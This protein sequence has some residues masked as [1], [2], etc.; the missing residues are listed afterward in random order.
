MPR[1]SCG[2]GIKIHFRVVIEFT[3]LFLTQLI[4]FVTVAKCQVTSANTLWC[5][6]HSH[7]VSN[8]FQLIGDGQTRYASS[9]HQYGLFLTLDLF[10]IQFGWL[11]CFGH[12]AHSKGSL[13][14][15]CAAAGDAYQIEEVS[16]AQTI[17]F[18]HYQ[19]V[20]LGQWVVSPSVTKN[21]IQRGRWITA[22]LFPAPVWRELWLIYHSRV[23]RFQ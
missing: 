23:G 5:L 3:Y 21:L 6:K 15:C 17:N 18:H 16:S 11:A 8:T 1:D 12:H 20:I 7:L 19:F 14:N 4:N 9:Q 22:W 10:E 2:A 13:V